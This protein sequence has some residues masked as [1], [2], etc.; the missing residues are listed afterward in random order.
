VFKAADPNT[1][2]YVNDDATSVFICSGECGYRV[3]WGVSP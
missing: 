2:S 1:Y 3:T